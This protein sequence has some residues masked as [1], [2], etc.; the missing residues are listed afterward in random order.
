MKLDFYDF[1]NKI[2]QSLTDRFNGASGIYPN[3]IWRLLGE[4]NRIL[5]ETLIEI[6]NNYEIENLIHYKGKYYAN[7]RSF[8]EALI[9][10]LNNSYLHLTFSK[11]YFE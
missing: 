6:I 2:S 10:D 9:I 8:V 3:D 5:F 11:L 4:N 1:E 7:T